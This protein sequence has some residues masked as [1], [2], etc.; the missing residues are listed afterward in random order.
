V[1]FVKTLPGDTHMVHI[2]PIGTDSP[3][4]VR[5]SFSALAR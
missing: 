5:V 3:L 1:D 4:R 2:E